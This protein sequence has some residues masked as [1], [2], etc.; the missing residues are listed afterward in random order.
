MDN[1]KI[2][3]L[4]FIQNVITRMNSNSFQL[5]GWLIAIVSALLALYA[6]GS[7]VIYIFIAIIPTIVF[8]CLDTIY[9]KQE[10]QYR[11]LY[12]DVIN[13]KSVKLFDMN[14]SI[15]K[16]S[17]WKVF[18]SKTIAGLYLS[19]TILLFLIGI[20]ILVIKI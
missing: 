2:K 6:N 1:E 7:N 20:I 11:A 4:E 16:F 17:F 8:W 18:L 9:L 13:N 5:K 19:I 15:Y 3:Y 14:A 10:K 12:K